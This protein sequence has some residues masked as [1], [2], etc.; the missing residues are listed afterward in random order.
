MKKF[1]KKVEDFTCERCDHSI[2]GTG[3]TNHCP[4][5]FYS[6]HVDINPGDRQAGCG[7]LMRVINIE[8]KDGRYIL[9]FECEKC[10]H[11]KKNKIQKQDNID[12]LIKLQEKINTELV[13]N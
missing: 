4:Q 6:K 12:N 8:L 2:Q 1:Q 10:Q 9:E 7:G 5:C 13:K 3:Y 11:R